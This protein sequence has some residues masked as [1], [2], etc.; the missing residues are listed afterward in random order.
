MGT[1][2]EYFLN[3]LVLAKVSGQLHKKVLFATEVLGDDAEH[4]DVTVMAVRFEPVTPEY[5]Q[6]IAQRL[7]IIGLSLRLSHI[8]HPRIDD[9]AQFC[10]YS[11]FE[12][13]RLVVVIVMFHEDRVEN[14][15]IL[16]V[17]KGTPLVADDLVRIFELLQV[18]VGRK[19]IGL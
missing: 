17:F 13:A 18:F 11:L 12:L 8:V 2:R 15:L 5:F 9:L 4:V 6:S 19:V 16:F 14:G 7:K 1:Y 10:Y 3:V